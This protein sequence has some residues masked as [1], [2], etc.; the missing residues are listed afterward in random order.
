[1]GIV[2]S[3]TKF[4]E[5]FRMGSFR[6]YVASDY[7]EAVKK[8]GAT[9]IIIPLIDDEEKIRK[10]VDICD[11]V[12]LSGG[13]D[14]CPFL[15]GEEISTAQGMIDV[16][17]DRVDYV[18]IEEVL[19]QNKGILGICRGMQ[20][21][22][23]YFGGSLAQDINTSVAHVQK[24]DKNIPTHKIEVEEK[25]ILYDL[26]GKEILVNSFHHQG[27][28]KV[29]DGIIVTAKSS[30]NIVEAIELKR[31]KKI[32]GVQWHP[33]MMEDSIEMELLFKEFVKRI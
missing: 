27:I 18:V 6:T 7:V 21:I 23:V 30:D 12:L 19:K 5:Y 33:E 22:N 16:L 1:I 13:D 17:R 8:A 32:F 28:E 25:S 9:P 10:I 20:I 24:S 2:S 29:G 4:S 26:F 14:I 11:G 3:R 31:N 15:Y